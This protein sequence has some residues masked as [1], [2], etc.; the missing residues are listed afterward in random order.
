MSSWKLVGVGPTSEA[1]S[2]NLILAEPAGVQDGDLLVAA[3]A[4]RDSAAFGVPSGWTLVAQNNSGN[5]S[6]SLFSRAASGLLA[7]AV[8]GS[9]SPS[10]TFSRSGGSVALGRVVAY[11]GQFGGLDGSSSGSS[12]VISTSLSAS[13]ITTTEDEGLI[14]AAACGA[15]AA[16]FSAF[17]AATNLRPDLPTPAPIP[18]QDR[19]S[20]GRIPLLVQGR[21]QP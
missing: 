1:S 10:L 11:R 17:N 21:A 2:G 5:T 7:Y 18:N 8:R 4:F 15:L 13:G 3:I 20:S 19:G 9:G 14:V 6:T 12:A 16:S